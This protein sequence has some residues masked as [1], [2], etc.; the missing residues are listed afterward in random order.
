MIRKLENSNR[1]RRVSESIDA[2]EE[3]RAE[4]LKKMDK[5][6]DM[7]EDVI[8]R[9]NDQ[10]YSIEYARRFDTDSA[11]YGI[12]NAMQSLDNVITYLSWLK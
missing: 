5:M 6:L 2:T 3:I 9:I 4:Y 1:N 7:C 11:D 12:R 8:D 10:K